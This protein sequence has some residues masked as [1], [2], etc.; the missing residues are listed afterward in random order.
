MVDKNHHLGSR[1]PEYALLGFLYDQPGYGYQIHH[2]LT[3]ELGYVWHVSQS[4]VYNII[5]R[6][7]TQGFILSTNQEQEKLPDR[8]IL[9]LSDTGRRRFEDW[10]NASSGSSVH[11]IRLEFITR[12]FFAQKLFPDK[13]HSLL[14]DQADEIDAALTRLKINLADIPSEQKFNHLGVELRIDQLRSVRVWLNNCFDEFGINI[15]KS[16]K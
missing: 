3:T 9:R 4:Q 16:K 2:R 15:Q 1:S 11:A 14:D 5:R 7:E 10:M 6:L 13:V 12:L 8:Q